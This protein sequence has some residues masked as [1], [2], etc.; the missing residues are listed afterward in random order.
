MDMKDRIKTITLSV[1]GDLS[2]FRML[3]DYF[4]AATIYSLETALH[5]SRFNIS[6]MILTEEFDNGS[7]FKRSNSVF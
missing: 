7:G 4:P 1:Q 6:I 2:A 3:M 5:L